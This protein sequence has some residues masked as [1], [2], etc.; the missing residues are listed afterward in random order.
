[1]GQKILFHLAVGARLTGD[2]TLKFQ[3]VK[4]QDANVLGANFGLKCK[5]QQVCPAAA[6]T[7]HRGRKG[8]RVRMLHSRETEVKRT[9]ATPRCSSPHPPC[10][11]GY[12]VLIHP[13]PPFL[14]RFPVPILPL[15]GQQQRGFSRSMDVLGLGE[16]FD[17]SPLSLHTERQTDHPVRLTSI[18]CRGATTTTKAWSLERKQRSAEQSRSRHRSTSSPSS[19]SL[20]LPPYPSLARLL[21]CTSRS[22]PLRPSKKLI[23]HSTHTAGAR[24]KA[25]ARIPVK[26]KSLLGDVCCARGKE[27]L[28]CSTAAATTTKQLFVPFT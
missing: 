19:P 10:G 23:G 13:L 24:Q 17:Q 2:S 9:M 7:A 3:K 28:L 6:D 15:D 21:T 12:R 16:S 1:M 18:T 14:S 20:S 4:V 26:T 8:W 22:S 27:R 25:N 5:V 11:L